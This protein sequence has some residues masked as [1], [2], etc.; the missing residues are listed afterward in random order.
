[1]SHCPAPSTRAARPLLV[2][3][4]ILLGLSLLAACGTT[5][6]GAEARSEKTSEAEPVTLT[7][8]RGKEI[9]LDRPAED[10]VALEWMEAENLVAL[11]VMPVG[12]ADVD[13]YTTWNTAAPLDDTVRDVGTRSEPSSDSIL[14]LEPDLVIMEA[15]GHDALIEE[16][17]QY[18]PVMVTVGSDADGNIAHMRKTF[19]SIA[20]AVGREE[21]AEAVLADLDTTL[22]DATA[23][24]ADADM[25][26]EDFLL[27]DGYLQGSSFVV[28]VFAEGSL[29]SELAEEVGLNNAWTEP[30]DEVW[31][32]S[33]T[34]IEGLTTLDDLRFFYSASDADPIE[35]G[36]LD[37]P[38]FDTLPWVQS[39]QVYKLDPGTWTFGGPA[40]CT[41]FVEQLVD[42]LA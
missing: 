13:G 20:E 8:S 38:I 35:D 30:G 1:M 41:K 24:L 7:D 5:E 3:L 9:T 26:G 23:A 22:A 27:A 40:S 10:V 29:F 25:D 14:D 15:E 36:T 17:E 39:G 31:G 34:D 32:L 28:R 21:E 4:T 16:L 33:M 11:G 37:S 12:V 19:S 6:D 42:K 18:V 2:A